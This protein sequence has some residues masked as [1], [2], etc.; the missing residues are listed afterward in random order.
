MLDETDHQIL[1][2]LQQD[3]RLSVERVAQKVGLSPTPVRRRIRKLEEAGIILGY[4]AVVDPE[5]AGMSLSLY[6]F[7]KLESRSR[8]VIEAFESRIRTLQEIETCNLV[9][10]SHDYMLFMHVRDMKHYDHY[11]HEILSDIPGIFEIQTSI[12]IS[13]IKVGHAAVR[14][15]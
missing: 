1:K 8:E 10:G 2:L 3:A 4:G 9:T 5:A 7:I 11:V 6:V 15:A 13:R 12:V 14:Q